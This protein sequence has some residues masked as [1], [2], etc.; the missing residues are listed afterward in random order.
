MVLDLYS[1]SPCEDDGIPKCDIQAMKYVI[2]VLTAGLSLLAVFI[3]R[4]VNPKIWL[5]ITV[6]G[7][8]SLLSVIV[9]FFGTFCSYLYQ[10]IESQLV[11]PDNARV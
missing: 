3:S 10:Q 1:K 5:V 8:L 7:L 2:L 6:L 4:K 9:F 11:D